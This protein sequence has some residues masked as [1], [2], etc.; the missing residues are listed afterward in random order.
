MTLQTTTKVEQPNFLRKVLQANSIF[1]ELSGITL[2]VGATPLAAFL[3][4]S[5]SIF[6]VIIGLSLVL[7]GVALF[8]LAG[9]TRLIRQVAVMA[10]SLDLIWVFGSG[11]IL[12]AGLLPLT[13]G[14]W[15][16]SLPTLWRFSQFCSSTACGKFSNKVSP[17]WCGNNTAPPIFGGAVLKEPFL[18]CPETLIFVDKFDTGVNRQV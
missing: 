18:L 12:F 10:I 9:Q 3:G 11:V 13:V 7:Y 5:E 1:S 6:L 15:W 14:G 8:L 17:N 2:V 16:L 4:L